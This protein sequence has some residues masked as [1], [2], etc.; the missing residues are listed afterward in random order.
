MHTDKEK[1]SLISAEV[2]QDLIALEENGNPRIL[3]E[4]IGLYLSS[5]PQV[6]EALKLVSEKGDFKSLHEIA[7]SFKSSCHGIGALDLA[8]ELE[9]IEAAAKK[10][11]PTVDMQ[12]LEEV[13]TNIRL[14]AIE[15]GS[16]CS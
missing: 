16:R 11:A 5:A 8:D 7:H 6:I 1:K 10:A 14:V 4:I 13:L 15:L 9:K 12:L 2:W 3:K